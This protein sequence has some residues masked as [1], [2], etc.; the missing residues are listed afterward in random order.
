MDGKDFLRQVEG[1][2]IQSESL[3]PARRLFVSP[4][5]DRGVKDHVDSQVAELGSARNDGCKVWRST[6]RSRQKF[7]VLLIYRVE[8]KD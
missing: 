1:T 5:G 7:D 2:V 4:V 8:H 6:T 3:S